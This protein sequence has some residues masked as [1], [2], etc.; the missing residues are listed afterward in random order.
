MIYGTT[1]DPLLDWIVQNA[2]AIGILA[3]VIVGLIRG[4]LVTGREHDRVLSERDRAID[5]V[6]AQAEATARA[7][8]VAEK[9]RSG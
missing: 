4:W 2:S 1:G 9:V 3:F 7:L 8:E 5:L 6:Y